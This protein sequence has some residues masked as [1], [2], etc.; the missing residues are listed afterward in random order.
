VSARNVILGALFILGITGAIWAFIIAEAGP[1]TSTPA[2]TTAEPAKP[3]KNNASQ[4][5]Q[6]TDNGATQTPDET[7]EDKQ[8]KLGWDAIKALVQGLRVDSPVYENLRF[9]NVVVMPDDTVCL[10]IFNGDTVTDPEQIGR[11]AF[12][13]LGGQ[14]HQVHR[15]GMTVDLWKRECVNQQG[16]NVYPQIEGRI[17]QMQQKMHDLNEHLHNSQ[18]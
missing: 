12:V 17:N 3:T 1:P 18:Q 15:D 10:S 16:I 6:A 9:D 11:I 13:Y 5:Q 2:A 14:I 7:R 4:T 8:L